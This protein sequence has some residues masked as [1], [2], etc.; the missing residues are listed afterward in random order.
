MA[1][2]AAIFIDGGYLD[3]ILTDEFSQIKI[4]YKK[5]ATELTGKCEPTP[6]LLRV[7]YY[8][9][10]PYRSSPPTPEESRR[11]AGA[12]RFF[13]A[14]N[15]KTFFE[16]RLGRL[17]SRGTRADGSIVL[18]Q[19]Q[20]DILMAIDIVRLSM[21]RSITHA[22]LVTGDSDFIP[23]IQIARDEGI[24]VALAHGGQLHNQLLTKIDQRIR[25]DQAFIDKILFA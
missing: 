8:H 9:C 11:F 10:E 25:L 18:E 3:H 21:R 24:Q 6:T 22:I 2:K 17:A 23:A 13:N 14:L 5:L 16:V 4:D 1:E 19:K 20:V 7:Y 12:Q 15:S